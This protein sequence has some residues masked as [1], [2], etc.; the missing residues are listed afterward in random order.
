MTA[1]GGGSSS[2]SFSSSSGA[3]YSSNADDKLGMKLIFGPW[4]TLCTPALVA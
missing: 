1:M 3:P 4:M 2:S